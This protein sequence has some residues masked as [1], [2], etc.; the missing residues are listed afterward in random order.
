MASDLTQQLQKAADVAV[1]Y[2]RPLVHWGFIPAVILVG[3]W[4]MATSM[5]MPIMHNYY[6]D[7][8]WPHLS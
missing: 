4:R 3:A 1:Q 5:G 7:T 6:F 2:G 8:V